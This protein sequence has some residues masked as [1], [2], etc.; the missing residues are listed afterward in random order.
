MTGEREW[1]VVF[2]GTYKGREIVVRHAHFNLPEEVMNKLADEG[3][4]LM[5]KMAER[6]KASNEAETR[7]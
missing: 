6:M 2:T 7:K 3:A 5:E 1:N 4:M